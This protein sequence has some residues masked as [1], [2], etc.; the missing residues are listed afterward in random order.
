MSGLQNSGA[1]AILEELDMTDV[2]TIVQADVKLG[3]CGIVSEDLHCKRRRLSCYQ[4]WRKANLVD[5]ILDYM[6]LC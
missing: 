3:G 5:D 6:R 1:R 2:S 4:V